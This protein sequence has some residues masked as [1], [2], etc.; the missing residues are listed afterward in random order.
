MCCVNLSYLETLSA[1]SIK[2]LALHSFISSCGSSSSN[3]IVLGIGK[4]EMALEVVA[5]L[6]LVSRTKQNSWES[7]SLVIVINYSILI[8]FFP[9]LPEGK[10]LRLDSVCIFLVTWKSLWVGRILATFTRSECAQN[11]HII[12]TDYSFMSHKFSLLG[13][14][15]HVVA[16]HE[17]RFSKRLNTTSFS[18][19]KISPPSGMIVWN[20]MVHLEGT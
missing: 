14:G 6:F 15:G 17:D 1:F 13:V 16:L 7:L 4:N 5:I 9:G 11:S 18:L 19:L 12:F 8:G 3:R 10:S 20:R 2:Q